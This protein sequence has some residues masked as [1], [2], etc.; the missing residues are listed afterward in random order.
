MNLEDRT[1]KRTSLT[2]DPLCLETET[3]VSVGVGSNPSLVVNIKHLRGFT[4]TFRRFTKD[5]N[6]DTTNE[7]YDDTDGCVFF[8]SQSL[9]HFCTRGEFMLY[10][11][12]LL[13]R[14]KLIS[15][16]CLLS[17]HVGSVVVHYT[18]TNKGHSK[19]LADT[20]HVNSPFYPKRWWKSKG[21]VRSLRD[22]RDPF[23]IYTLTD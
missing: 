8:R 4:T 17:L 21:Y 2:T 19:T 13:K 3:P 14:P 11:V 7:I 12:F 6:P 1:N 5:I 20:F 18:W 9:C 10:H 22:H 16:T 23:N 15:G